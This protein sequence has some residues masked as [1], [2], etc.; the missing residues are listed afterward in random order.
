MGATGNRQSSESLRRFIAQYTTRGASVLTRVDKG[1]SALTTLSQPESAQSAYVAYAGYSNPAAPSL[2]RVGVYCRYSTHNQDD[3]YSL[4]AQH[5]AA[6]HE[7]AVVGTWALYYYDE[8][9][10]SAFTDNLAKRPVFLK[11]LQDAADGMLDIIAVHRTDRFSRKLHITARVVSVLVESGIQ[12]VSLQEQLKVTTAADTLLLHLFGAL[13]EHESAHKGKQIRNGKR[14]RAMHGLHGCRVPYGY[15]WNG[16]HAVAEPDKP[17]EDS[18][19]T[20]ADD[21]EGA[22]SGRYAWNGIQRLFAL[23]LSGKTDHEIASALNGEGYRLTT[24]TRARNADG[25]ADTARPFTQQTVSILRRTV[26]YRPFTPD[27]DRGTVRS[28]GQDYR[29]Q[30]EAATTWENWQTMQQIASTR[31]KGWGFTGDTLHV[32]YTAEF[33][34]LAVCAVCGGRLYVERTVYLAGTPGQRIYERYSCRAYTRNTECVCSRQWARVGEMRALWVAWMREHLM[35]PTEWEQ[36]VRDALAEQ[37]RAQTS[38][39]NMPTQLQIQRERRQWL[40]KRERATDLYADGLKDRQWMLAR[41]AEA[42]TA[43]TRLEAD[44]RPVEIQQGRLIDAGKA[45]LP[46]ADAWEHMNTVEQIE[47]AS[48]LIAPRG[49]RMHLYG[50]AGQVNRWHP[51]E[52]A[53][54]PPSGAIASVE[55]QPAFRDLL[56]L[57]GGQQHGVA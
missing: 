9:A 44:L 3:G 42:D 26:Y 14:Q 51:V 47:W 35:M 55:L 4:E 27:D 6:E 28:C 15:R 17:P 39:G 19:D 46:L 40:Q 23:A 7:A 20:D 18:R 11:M 43:L 50:R 37:L 41:V 57:L 49:L 21:D 8:P 36:M 2:A 5:E 29:G 1:R 24:P 45:L 48:R 31:R 34:G 54:T 53:R 12:F 13:A 32:P 22:E 38:A 16:Q 33:R 52:D 10:T 56:A 25:T 30:H